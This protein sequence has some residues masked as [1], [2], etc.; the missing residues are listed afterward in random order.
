MD[1]LVTVQIAFR[2]RQRIG[3]LIVR[4]IWMREIDTTIDHSDGD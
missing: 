3:P 4:Q 1:F 2:A